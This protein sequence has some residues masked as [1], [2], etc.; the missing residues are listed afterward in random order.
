MKGPSNWSNTMTL[1]NIGKRED[2]FTLSIPVHEMTNFL[3]Y[4]ILTILVMMIPTYCARRLR[5]G[6]ILGIQ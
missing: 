6:G 5:A 1:R 2:T 3:A 4:M